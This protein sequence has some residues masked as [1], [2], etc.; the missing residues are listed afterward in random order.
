MS[1]NVMSSSTGMLMCRRYQDAVD[2]RVLEQG[3][4]RR[5]NRKRKNRRRATLPDNLADLPRF[6]EWL[7]EEVDRLED[8]GIH[9]DPM[10]FE[11]SRLPLPMASRYRSMKSQGNHFRVASAEESLPTYDSGICATF[12][13][14]CINGLRDRSP[15]VADLEYVGELQEIIELHYPGHYESEQPDARGSEPLQDRGHKTVL[16]VGSWVKAN[17][18]GVHATIKTDRWGFTLA[19]FDTLSGLGSESFAFPIQCDQVF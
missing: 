19:N 18:R 10:L 17:Y 9:L 12:R 15:V 6:S 14:P 2:T 1:E 7:K 11:S 5:I 4:W 8:S 13:R 16:F 3:Q